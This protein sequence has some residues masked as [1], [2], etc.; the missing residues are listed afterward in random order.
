MRGRSK[1]K[2]KAMPDGQNLLPRIPGANPP[3]PP[4]TLWP[5]QVRPE[6]I[7][8]QYRVV[9]ADPQGNLVGLPGPMPFARTLSTLRR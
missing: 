8:D 1:G 9:L 4:L 5:T 3:D 2:I 6:L 7:V